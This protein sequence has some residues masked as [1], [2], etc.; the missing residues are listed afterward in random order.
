MA[1]SLGNDLGYSLTHFGLTEG[2]ARRVQRKR[3]GS[4]ESAG[5]RQVSVP[6]RV[7]AMKR[8]RTGTR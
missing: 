4:T 8:L 6:Q 7:G 3:K 1:A 2:E 5:R